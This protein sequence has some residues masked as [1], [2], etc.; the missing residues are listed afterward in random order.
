MKKYREGIHVE[1]RNTGK[2]YRKGT[3][4]TQKMQRMQ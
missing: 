1:R 4:R 3:Q 2:E